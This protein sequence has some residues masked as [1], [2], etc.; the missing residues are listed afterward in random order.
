MP[1]VS[2]LG[3]PSLDEIGHSRESLIHALSHESN[4]PSTEVAAATLYA[5][6]VEPDILAVIEQ[7][8]IQ[9]IDP[10]SERLFFRGLH[11]LGG[12]QFTAVYRPLIAFLRGPQKRIDR[13]L[14]DVVTET[15]SKI[16]AGVF[17]GDEEPLRTLVTDAAVD[18]FVRQAALQALGFLYF[19]DRIDRKGFEQFLLRLDVERAWPPDDDVMW[20][21]WMSVIGVLG[22]EAFAPRVRAAFA[23]G[24]IA[25]HW[26][27]EG[28]F[29]ELLKAAI[30]R[31]ADRTRLASEQLGYI[32]DVLQELERWPTEDDFPA[33]DDAAANAGPITGSGLVDRAARYVPA[34]NPFRG[35]GRNDPCPCGSGKKAKKCCLQ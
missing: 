7:A 3:I 33:E 17:D 25:P 27:S 28:H 2:P 10:A 18:P 15:L 26:C 4:L 11:I 29:D 24:R 32:E 8:C 9:D 5:D 30:E 31:P 1:S 22:M 12:R 19:E 14:G 23:D 13:L 16:L 34:V 20:H 21:A 6:Q 35:V